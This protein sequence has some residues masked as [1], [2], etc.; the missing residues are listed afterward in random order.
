MMLHATMQ[1]RGETA[2]VSAGGSGGALHNIHIQL[3]R[4]NKRANQVGR[5]EYW[6]V[7]KRSNS[8]G[9]SP[10]SSGFPEPST[11]PR[12]SRFWWITEK[13]LP[14]SSILLRTC[15]HALPSAYYMAGRESIASS[16]FNH[17]IST[18]RFQRGQRPCPVE[19][20]E[21][22]SASHFPLA[23][24]LLEKPQSIAFGAA[25]AFHLATCQFLRLRVVWRPPRTSKS[26]RRLAP[27]LGGER[28]GPEL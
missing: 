2:T 3:P 17:F 15:R 21:S 22:P 28:E 11:S 9:N 4:P 10:F 18:P 26:C 1:H 5:T 16:L 6:A 19:S 24:T 25:R 23:P 8:R 12:R 13:L 20:P 7:D 14:L 27:K